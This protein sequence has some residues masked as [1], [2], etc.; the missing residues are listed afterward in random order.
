MANSKR[1]ARGGQYHFF[2]GYPE[3]ESQHRITGLKMGL[4]LEGV[5]PCSASGQL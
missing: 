3:E 1:E 2:L 4:E 5:N